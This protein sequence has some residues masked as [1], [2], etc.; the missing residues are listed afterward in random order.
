M[1]VPLFADEGVAGGVE[2]V[3]GVEFGF[4]GGAQGVM[5]AGDGFEAVF[6]FEG[7]PVG[8]GLDGQVGVDVA[9]DPLRGQAAFAGGGHGG[10][11]GGW[12]FFDAVDDEAMI[13]NAHR[14]TPSIPAAGRHRG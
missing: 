11:L 8:D 7:V 3:L 12:M 6:G 1:E 9:L 2:G 4:L 5:A 14:M 13:A 10:L